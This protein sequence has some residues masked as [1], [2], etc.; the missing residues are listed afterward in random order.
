[1][2]WSVVVTIAARQYGHATD[3][4]GDPSLG[5]RFRA[6]DLAEQLGLHCDRENTASIARQALLSNSG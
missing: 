4:L 1:M 6:E 3:G 2:T 5:L